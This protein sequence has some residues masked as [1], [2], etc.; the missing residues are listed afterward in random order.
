VTAGVVGLIAAV[1]VL[2]VD[3]SVTGVATGVIAV[4]SFL[5]LFRIESRL[6]IPV[7]IIG[8]GVAGSLLGLS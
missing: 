2:I 8:A 7:V 5:L 4:V 6:T 1:V 3:D